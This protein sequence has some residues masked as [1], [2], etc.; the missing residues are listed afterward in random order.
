MQAGIDIT[1]SDTLELWLAAVPATTQPTYAIKYLEDNG[2]TITQGFVKGTL[3]GTTHVTAVSS[4]VSGTTRIVTWLRVVNN[5]TST[6]RVY[7]GINTGGTVVKCSSRA[8]ASD[9]DAELV[10]PQVQPATLPEEIQRAETA[11][12]ANEAAI[13]SEATTRAEEDS[14]ALKVANNLSDI[15]DADLA[16]TNI[17][18]GTSS[19]ALGE[20]E[21]SA[22]RGDHGKIAYDHSQTTSGNPHNVTKA[23]VGLGNCD[24]TSDANKPVSTAQDTAI[25]L[26]ASKSG[27]TFTGRINISGSFSDSNSLVITNTDV[28]NYTQVKTV[29]TGKTYAFGVGNASALATERR[30]NWYVYNST[31]ALTMFTFS[32]TG[33]LS[34]PQYTASRVLTTDA[35]KNVVASN[36]TATELGYL[37]GLTSSLVTLLASKADLPSVVSWTPV[38]H[39]GTTE[40]T[41]LTYSSQVGAAYISGSRM[42]LHCSLTVSNIGT[43]GSGYAY[44]GGLPYSVS[45][46]MLRASG[47]V[48]C[49]SLA[50][51]TYQAKVCAVSS[52]G[53][54]PYIMLNTIDHSNIITY[55]TL[56]S[57]SSFQ[58]TIILD[59]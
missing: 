14:L 30:N 9:D 56:N 18:A 4:P 43:G 59:K 50:S 22:Y 1:S 17:G 34:L 37:S 57:S 23:Q 15:A 58:F 2:T 32:P 28:A 45:N 47:L 44:I 36:T 19:L 53:M 49:S 20:T 10:S 46:S 39:F 27:D 21:T 5:D 25:G 52:S 8:I 29:G 26:K 3:T 6:C 35:S 16:R 40:P 13:L 7:A 48:F 24:N 54:S 11:E 51:S 31:D 12:E 42:E 55:S 38:L 41:G 33:V